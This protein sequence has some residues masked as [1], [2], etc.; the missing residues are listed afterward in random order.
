MILIKIYSRLW[1]VNILFIVIL[2]VIFQKTE[3]K[4][5]EN[6]KKTIKQIKQIK[7]IT[8]NSVE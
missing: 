1:D 2:S 8:N 5:K 7:Q 6:N 3:E 4:K